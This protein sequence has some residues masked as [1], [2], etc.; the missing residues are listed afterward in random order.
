MRAKLSFVFSG[1]LG[2]WLPMAIAIGVAA[3]I[4]WLTW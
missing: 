4:V 3:L 2:Y 1:L